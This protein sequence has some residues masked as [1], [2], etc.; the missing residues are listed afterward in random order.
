VRAGLLPVKA[1]MEREP[2]GKG[3]HVPP[4]HT[5]PSRYLREPADRV[6]RHACRG[7]SLLAGRFCRDTAAPGAARIGVV[8]HGMAWRELATDRRAC[9]LATSLLPTLPEYPCSI[10]TR[11]NPTRDGL[12]RGLQNDW[13]T[14]CSRIRIVLRTPSRLM[15]MHQVATACCCWSEPT[16]H[17]LRCLPKIESTPRAGV[18]CL[19]K[20]SR[21][22]WAMALFGCW[23]P[24]R[25]QCF[26]L[27]PV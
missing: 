24:A 25:Q 14:V 26:S 19:Q 18:F 22:G 16:G 11:R 6:V 12:H 8:G 7:I 15:D 1:P 13:G 21:S 27:T 10:T 4:V 17:C 23:L 9:A 2:P 3:R 20:R 5:S